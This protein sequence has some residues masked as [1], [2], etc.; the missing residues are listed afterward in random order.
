[1]N[2]VPFLVSLLPIPE[3]GEAQPGE[4]WP[5]ETSDWKPEKEEN[6]LKEAEA[7]FTHLLEAL[8]DRI[9][10]HWQVAR[11]SSGSLEEK[12]K[13]L[14]RQVSEMSE[15][16]TLVLIV[17]SAHES[18][19]ELFMLFQRYI[20]T[21]LTHTRRVFTIITGR[22]KAPIWGSPYL[23]KPRKDDINPMEVEDILELLADPDLKP[24]V[25]Q[26]EVIA[27][28][29]G[30]YPGSA[31]L[32]AESGYEDPYAAVPWVLDQLLA[33]VPRAEMGR[34]RRYLERICVFSRPFK[35]SEVEKLL[36]QMGDGELTP[37]AAQEAFNRLLEIHL[38]DWHSGGYVLNE[39][40]RIP[41]HKYLRKIETQT[42]E[43]YRRSAIQLFE[44][45]AA[46]LEKENRL[47]NARYYASY[48]QELAAG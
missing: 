30:G 4:W 20:L 19:K 10:E 16:K 45:L 7:A 28:I 13:Y 21:P 25:S 47:N 5:P 12:S 46:D 23:R 2:L 34:M 24:R 27:E 22:G 42:W 36:V 43:Y 33:E 11:L 41:L 38:M 35:E 8:L 31:R 39:S 18:Q 1:M 15:N 26:P 14:Q 32:F 3:G 44:Q 40:I 37:E 6:A 9:S 48:A 29:S 17:D